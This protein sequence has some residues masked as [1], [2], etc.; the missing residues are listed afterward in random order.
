VEN[1][2]EFNVFLT[3]A[4]FENFRLFSKKT[5]FEFSPITILVGPNGSGKS[6]L[7]KGLQFLALNAKAKNF[8][9]R[10]KAEFP[11]ISI[12]SFDHVV[13]RDSNN[14]KFSFSLSARTWGDDGERLLAPFF[15]G[16]KITFEYFH[17]KDRNI[18]ELRNISILPAG[19]SAPIIIIQK[20]D[21]KSPYEITLNKLIYDSC[22]NFLSSLKEEFIAIYSEL[23]K[24]ELEWYEWENMIKDIL[25]NE[26]NSK[27]AP[28]KILKALEVILD[29]HKMMME[30]NSE[31][32]FSDF[33]TS[34]EKFLDFFYNHIQQINENYNY[35]SHVISKGA[36]SELEIKNNIIAR[37]IWRY[38]ID[39][40][41]A[42]KTHIIN[43]FEL[44]STNRNEVKRFYT[45]N[46]NFYLAKKI[47][48]RE[49][50]KDEAVKLLNI[51]EIGQDIEVDTVEGEFKKVILTQNNGKKFDISDLGHGISQLIPIIIDPDSFD[52]IYGFK[53]PKFWMISEPEANLHPKLQ[54]KLANLF[55]HKTKDTYSRFLIES[56]SEYL[57]R[58]LQYL[59]AKGDLDKENVQL[60]Y[61][62]EPGQLHDGED[63][64]K[65][66]NIN[67]DGSLTDDFGSGFFDESDKIALSLFFLNQSQKN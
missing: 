53:R 55:V 52:P 60:Y 24:P 5:Y 49:F 27:K 13:S 31:D 65:K 47:F 29:L 35:K 33:G 11:E 25:N 19:L 43:D 63:V 7:I 36:I 10:L 14:D 18:A 67:E 45:Q 2:R 6:T 20:K 64:V 15:S 3:G 54:S 22:F 66:I 4:G 9:Q 61:F 42:I 21:L 30:F 23:Y 12:T 57:I 28:E 62:Y 51:L 48:S 59:V 46:D 8:P 17:I 58:N 39:F 1:S 40:L 38:F 41:E 56:H 34:F 16:S 32:N 50:K 37:F 44:V 26:E